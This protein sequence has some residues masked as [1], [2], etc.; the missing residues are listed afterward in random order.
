M[1]KLSGFGRIAAALRNPNYG[2][3]TAGSCVSLIGTWMQRIATGWLAWELTHSGT[4]LGM[5]AFAD[6]FPTVVVGPIAGA[7]ADRWNRLTVTKISQTLGMCQ[8]FAL[9]GFTA[10]GLID[11]WLL[12]GLTL[13]LGAVAAFNQP[14]RL[15]LIPSLVPREH[16]GSAVAIN[17]VVFN[18]ARFVGPAVAGVAIVAGGVALAFA[19][20]AVSFAAFLVALS[21]VR[22]APDAA[23]GPPRA[24]Q[25]L[26][27][28]LA[29]GVG[30]VVRHAGIAPL[31]LLLIVTSIGVRPLVELMPAFAARV[32]ASGAEG[33]AMLTA[34][35]GVGAIVGGLW[36]AGRGETKGLTGVVLRSIAGMGVVTILF[37]LS[38]RLWIAAPLLTVSGFFVVCAGVGTQTLIQLAVDTAMRGRV[39][40]LYGLIFRGG[41]AIGA[42]MMGTA[43]DYVGLRWPVITGATLVILAWAAVR[44]RAARIRASL[45]GPDGADRDGAS[46]G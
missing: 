8:A 1:I 29:E 9:F 4:W 20:N 46:G 22:L 44:T 2:V 25:G 41:P 5:I 3:Y 12:F 31:L 16:L 18:L 6:L 43:S 45:E 37:A 36:L 42:L 38:D 10:S 30:Y 40:S 11:I 14:A 17:A 34:A 33:L 21:R 23:E 15:A 26:G 28:A 39:L 7:A 32:F 35:V 27:G 13:F 19:L 24:R